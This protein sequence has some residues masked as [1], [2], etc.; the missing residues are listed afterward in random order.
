M[1]IPALLG[2]DCT[3]NFTKIDYSDGCYHFSEDSLPWQ[4]AGISCGETGGYFLVVETESE[5]YA[6]ANKV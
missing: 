6:I 1:Y 3:E 4:E 2:G 5:N